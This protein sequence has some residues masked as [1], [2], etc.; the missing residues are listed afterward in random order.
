M[1]CWFESNPDHFL[2]TKLDNLHTL[3]YYSREQETKHQMSKDI[4]KTLDHAVAN[5]LNVL[6]K[7]KH[8]VGK[9]A[10]VQACFE[11]ANL[12]W[13]YYS[14]STM[15]PWVD[16]IGVPREKTD[17]DGM[18]YLDLIRP[19]D[20]AYDEVEAIFFDELNR[21][22]KKI[23]NAV[24]ELIQFKSINGKKFK[25]LKI[26]WAAINPDDEEGTYDVEKLDPA[27]V[28]R[29]QIH[30]DVPNE[31]DMAYFKRAYPSEGERAVK[32][33]QSL[34]D[35]TKVF[36]SPRRLEYALQIL[37]TDGDVRNVLDARSNVSS[38]ISTMSKG[39]PLEICNGLLQKTSTEVQRYMMDNNSYK[40]IQ[41]TIMSE[42]RILRGL[43]R[44]IPSEVL[45]KE[46]IPRT[47]ANNTKLIQHVS[48][49]AEMFD[50][51]TDK[52]LDNRATYPEAI[53]KS[54]DAHKKRKER[55]ETNALSTSKTMMDK[56][57]ALKSS[58]QDIE[59]KKIALN[60]KIFR[61][62]DLTTSNF[63]NLTGRKVRYTVTQAER[64]SKGTMTSE[65]ALREYLAK[66]VNNGSADSDTP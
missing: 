35:K 22:H 16:F 46:L 21:A 4:N 6:M 59:E 32:W 12:K 33:W 66:I 10:M 2:I 61:V 9:T 40:H 39:D 30:I 36:V 50:T 26:V 20:L 48:A 62:G 5:N 11:A 54:F 8:G 19:R 44:F 14:A 57:S 15:D 27:Q 45:L 31:P 13:K 34:D 24:M 63:E 29:F 37:K 18:T 38:F 58:F 65:D 47:G 23:R 28:D 52:I 3:W 53:T 43:A 1:D 55:A 41:P 64:I 17:K 7:G 42:E 60:G 51:L 49:N 56:M 25:N